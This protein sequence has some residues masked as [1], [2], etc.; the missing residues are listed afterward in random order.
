MNKV[1]NLNIETTE[2]E[3]TGGIQIQ[4]KKKKIKNGK[5]KKKTKK[6]KNPI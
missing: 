2:L 3:K 5:L 4:T 1:L 6:T